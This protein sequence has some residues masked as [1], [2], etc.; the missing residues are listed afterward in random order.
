MVLGSLAKVLAFGESYKGTC[1]CLGAGASGA[2]GAASSRLRRA[3][4]LAHDQS[5]SDPGGAPKAFR[6]VG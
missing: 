5:R 4:A 2:V 1:W 3:A 6:D